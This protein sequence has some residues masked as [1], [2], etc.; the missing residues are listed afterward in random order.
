MRLAAAL[1]LLA[2]PAALLVA[3]GPGR[4]AAASPA[5]TADA[6][7]AADRAMSR[8]IEVGD[9]AAFAR[10]VAEDAVFSGGT[11]HSVGRAAVA[12]DWARYFEPDGP[13]LTWTPEEA[14]LATSGDLGYTIGRYRWTGKTRDGKPAETQGQYLTVWRRDADGAYRALFDIAL[15]PKSARIPGLVRRTTRTVTS[16]GKDL[17]A[18]VGTWTLTP[19]GAP[20]GH[21]GWVTVWRRGADGALAE[22]VSTAVRFR[23]PPSPAGK[24]P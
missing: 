9:R 3:A 18:S 16:G 21:G 23:D 13:R 4:A 22:A 14:V 5:A 20:P 2:P 7:R 19:A 17:E 1:L 24:K 6:L 8:A 11:E 15:D 12:A 10:L